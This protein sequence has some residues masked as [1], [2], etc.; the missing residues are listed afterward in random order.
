MAKVTVE[1]H[2]AVALLRLNNG[3]INAIS[4][5]LLDDTSDAVKRIKREFKGM[6]LAGGDKFFCIG[7]DLP[8]L[9]ELGRSE[10]AEFY[11]KLNQVSLDLYT[12]PIPTACAVAGHATAGGAI[13]AITTDF[14]FI[15]TGRKFIGLNEVKIGLPV[16]YL[17]DSILRQVVGDRCATDMMYKGE[18]L[19]PDGAAKIGLVD[20]VFAPE[21]LEEQALAKIAE[22]AAFPPYGFTVI[23]NNRVETVRLRYEAMRAVD[24]ELFL[25]CWFNPAVRELLKEAAQKF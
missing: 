8:G 16:P 15:A 11:S 19:E 25:D 12:L 5:E 13:W 24:T 14:R 4:F 21:D 7:L 9:L 20:A 22:L 2:D 1:A 10:M 18:F 23:K 3:V 6:V 17:A